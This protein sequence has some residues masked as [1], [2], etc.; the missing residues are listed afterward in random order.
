MKS[1][2]ELCVEH[3]VKNIDTINNGWL[4]KYNSYNE[5]IRVWYDALK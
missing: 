2:K 4:R 3:Y 5:L 1:L